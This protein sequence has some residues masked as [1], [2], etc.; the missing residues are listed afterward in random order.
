MT[1]EERLYQEG[2]EALKQR[3]FPLARDLFTRLLKLNRQNAEYWIGMSAAVETP[4]E[5][6]VCLREALKFDSQN[7]LAIRGLRLIGEDN[8]FAASEGVFTS[9]KQALERA[10]VLVHDAV[11]ASE[12]DDLDDDEQWAYEI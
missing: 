9:A 10:Q 4:K 3:D 6:G 1:P 11:D 8:V 7:F 5:R 12:I 2:L